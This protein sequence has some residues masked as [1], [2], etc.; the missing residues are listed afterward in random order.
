RDPGGHGGGELEA[1]RAADVVHDQVEPAES[2]RVHGGGAKADEPGPGVVEGGGAGG[3]PAPGQG[4]RDPAPA[5]RGQLAESFAG[6]ET[7]GWHA[8]QAHHRL[9]ARWAGFPDEAAD[10]SGRKTPPGGAVLADHIVAVHLGNLLLIAAMALVAG[11]SLPSLTW[12][13]GNERPR[14]AL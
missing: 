5:Q 7:R 3:E 14:L 9:A 8:V 12:T 10:A 6:Q 13:S 1:H 2:E 11:G 4:E